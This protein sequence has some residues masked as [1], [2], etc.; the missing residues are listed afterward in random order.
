MSKMY[1]ATE[2]KQ[3]NTFSVG[4]NFHENVCHLSL[5]N[6]DDE[7]EMETDSVYIE[8]TQR[9]LKGLIKCLQRF[10]KPEEE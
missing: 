1:T 8:L 3:L 5:F 9:E 7:T 2:I 6:W 4:G 10:V